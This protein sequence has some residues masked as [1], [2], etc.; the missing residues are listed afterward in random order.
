MEKVKQLQ[1]IKKK[2][3]KK[4]NA[5]SQDLDSPL[6]SGQNSP[7]KSCPRRTV[8]PFYVRLIL[9]LRQIDSVFNLQG[10]K[11]ERNLIDHLYFIV[12]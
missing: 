3:L 1:Q 8:L 5:S 2:Q 9:Y 7:G 4:L 6:A 11:V 12:S 10:E